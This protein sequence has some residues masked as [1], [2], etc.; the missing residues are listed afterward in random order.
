MSIEYFLPSF[1]S[2]LYI[3]IYFCCKKLF[4]LIKTQLNEF[5]INFIR[6]LAYHL[7]FEIGNYWSIILPIIS[8]LVLDEMILK[9]FGKMIAYPEPL[10]FLIL[11]RGILNPLSEEILIRGLMFGCLLIYIFTFIIEK[12]PI[13]E[14]DIIF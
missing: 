6:S 11:I 12:G 1:F 14:K 3:I 10:I 9:L 8:V 4:R 2:I 5:Q 7:R 13:K